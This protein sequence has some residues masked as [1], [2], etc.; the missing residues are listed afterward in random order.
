[1]LLPLAQA[2]PDNHLPRANEKPQGCL[3]GIVGKWLVVGG[4]LGTDQD[5]PQQDEIAELGGMLTFCGTSS[6]IGM[7]KSV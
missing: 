6:T 4:G 7:T 3:K 1:M 2:E 5:G